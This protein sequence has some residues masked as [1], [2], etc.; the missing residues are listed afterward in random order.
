MQSTYVA[1]LENEKKF[2][3]QNE[4][5]KKRKLFLEEISEIKKRKLAVETGIDKYSIQA[6]KKQDMSVLTKA[7]LFRKTFREGKYCKNF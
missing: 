6:E 4:K 1:A 3:S 2:A 7:N 5:A